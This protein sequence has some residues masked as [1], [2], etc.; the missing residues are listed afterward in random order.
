MRVLAQ[1]DGP[2]EGQVPRMCADSEVVGEQSWETT[3]YE[4]KPYTERRYLWLGSFTP[5]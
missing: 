4:C 3:T 5:P 1:Y 2:F